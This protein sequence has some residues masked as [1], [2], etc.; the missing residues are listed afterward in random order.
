MQQVTSSTSPHPASL[1]AY[2]RN[3]W[4][5]IPIPPGTK[6]P[7]TKGW[8]KKE[9]VVTDHAMIPAGHGIGLAHAYSGT[10][11][12]DIDDW[13][14]AHLA[15][16]EQG[17]D[18]NALYQALDS[19]IIH[20]G[21][22]GRGKLLFKMPFGAA[23]PSKKININGQTSYELRCGT[24]DG[25]TVQD[26]L[27]PSIHPVTQQPYQWAGHGNWQ[28]LPTIPQP[29]LDFW[30]GLIEKDN[31]RSIPT[32]TSINT[33][34][35][36]IAEALNHIDPSI[37]RDQW[38][39]VG[40]A[41]HWAGTQMGDSDQGL[42]L[43]D[44][45]SKGSSKYAGE[46]DV[47]TQWRSFK[48]REDGVKLGT[49]FQIAGNYGWKR[50]IPDVNELF[51]SVTP[52][53]PGS[54]ATTEHSI[55]DPMN[56]IKGLRPSAPNLDLSLFPDVLRNRAEEISVFMGSD[57]LVSV[58]AGMA[59]ISGAIDSRTSLELAPGY[60]V[61]PIL[62]FMTIGSP[63]ERK[64]PASKPMIEP[65]RRIEREDRPHFKQ[66]HLQWEGREA[67][68]SAA[69]KAFLDYAQDPSSMMSN[70][71]IPAV[72]EL[73]VEPSPL[74]MVISDITSQKLVRIASAQ[75]R[76]ML[77]HL[78]EMNGWIKKIA[79]KNGS[80]D[81]STWTES[82]E[83]S[84][85]TMDRVGSGSIHCDTL[86]I[87]IYGNIQPQVYWDNVKALAQDGLLQRFCPAILRTWNKVPQPPGQGQEAKHE[88]DWEMI[89][90]TAYALPA[91]KYTLSPEAYQ[92]FRDFQY[93][94]QD[95][96]D[97]ER[98]LNA[99][100]RYMTAYGKLEGLAGRLMLVFHT[101]QSPFQ[102]TVTE[103]TAMRVI[104]FIRTYV[105]PALRF[106][107]NG[108]ADQDESFEEWIINHIVQLSGEVQTVTLRDLKRS[109]KNR[110]KTL[111][112]KGMYSNYEVDVAIRD[113]M[114]GLEQCGYVILVDEDAR[115]NSYTWSVNPH[116]A[117]MFHDYRKQ[118]IIA[119]QKVLDDCYHK[120]TESGRTENAVHNKAIGFNTEW[121]EEMKD[122]RP[123]G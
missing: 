104:D 35:T 6:G 49:F 84:E 54:L 29:L 82:Y 96:K 123:R 98:I 57:P 105:I 85:Y 90:R 18:I 42:W 14:T 26:V 120:L 32:T 46:R 110:I 44:D 74:R 80:E 116:I 83:G 121:R 59:A 9:N 97:R 122:E 11:A 71:A 86:A 102:T 41:L 16:L 73:D 66:R 36:E 1:E 75:P 33:S 53:E 19:V 67:A 5:L 10:M 70:D 76:G 117:T 111:T 3:G 100:D 61:P 55:P 24:S 106:L 72:P 109:S 81:R 31:Q 40:M 15:L 43:W 68:Y 99:N 27:P 87:S 25:M 21:R 93:W 101:M 119:H 103:N 4:K 39:Q 47:M 37:N 114:Y 78:D 69:K 13:G 48:N 95:R 45:W 63:S 56:L 38:V 58:Y 51:G 88:N 20:S 8:N 108:A 62:W 28:N 107:L 89:I 2:T 92:V 34:W 30:N 118:R 79:D 113:A 7:A 17:V 65:L 22:E 112:K 91:M 115:R 52:S 64:S 23:L 12:L 50:P 94:Y 77:C 60:E